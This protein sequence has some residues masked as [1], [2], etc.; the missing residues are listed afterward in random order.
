MK[1][2]NMFLL[3]AGY[4]A[5]LLVALKF[6]KK[7]PTE[8]EK[9]WNSGDDRYNN[10]GKNLL[11]IHRNLFETVEETIFSPENKKRIAEYKERFL[12]ELDAFK[13]ESEVTIKEWKKKGVA[14]KD[15][16]EADLRD[17]YDRRLELLEQAKKK[18]LELIEETREGGEDMVEEG[19]KLAMKIFDQAKKQLDA[20]YKESKTKLSKMKK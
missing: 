2:G 8:L 18:G 5:G 10:I 11:D 15:E 1:K 19:K 17:L 4:L 20:M 16:I 3:G 9:D 14:K 13:K 12:V 6:N 7:S